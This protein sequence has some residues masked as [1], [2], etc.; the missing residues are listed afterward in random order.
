MSGD[1]HVL[2]TPRRKR[3]A[4]DCLLLEG[5]REAWIVCYSRRFLRLAKWIAGDDSLTGDFL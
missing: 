2:P 3:A 4:K 5:N 1:F